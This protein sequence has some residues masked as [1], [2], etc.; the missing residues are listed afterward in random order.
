MKL[1]FLFLNLVFSPPI[2][3]SIA[4]V[5]LIPANLAITL[6]NLFKVFGWIE[7]GNSP[8]RLFKITKQYAIFSALFKNQKIARFI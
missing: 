2:V 5:S 6:T 3:L 8:P 7:L 1:Y 4:M